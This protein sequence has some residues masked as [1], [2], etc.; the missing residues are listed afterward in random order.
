MNTLIKLHSDNAG[1]SV[2]ENGKCSWIVPK[3][4]IGLAIGLALLAGHAVAATVTWDGDAGNDHIYG[5]GADNWVDGSEPADG[6][7][8]VFPGG[9]ASAPVRRRP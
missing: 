9:L 8:A 1:S 3:W 5:D 6:D 7:D 2:R 4:T